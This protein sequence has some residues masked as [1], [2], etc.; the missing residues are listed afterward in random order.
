MNGLDLNRRSDDNRL[1]MLPEQDA[2]VAT[3]EEELDRWLNEGGA[4]TP[5]D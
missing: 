4:L 2:S 3:T 1:D 5:D